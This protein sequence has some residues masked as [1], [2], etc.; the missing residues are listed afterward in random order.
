MYRQK[1]KNV[2]VSTEEVADVNVLRG[3][4][5]RGAESDVIIAP[6]LRLPSF[7]ALRDSAQESRD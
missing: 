4:I 2:F 5:Y 1:V 3:R 6:S 7:S